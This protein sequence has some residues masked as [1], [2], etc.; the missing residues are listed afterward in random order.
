MPL[1]VNNKDYQTDNV[2]IIVIDG[3]RYTETWGSHSPTNI[4][5]QRAMAEQGVVFNNFLNED[6]TFTLSGHSAITTGHYGL[7]S[8]DGHELPSYH[9]IFQEFLKSRMFPPDSAWIITSKDKL[10]ALVDTKENQWRGSYLPSI[11]AVKRRDEETLAVAIDILTNH[12][13]KLS[14]IH[15]REPDSF[16]HSNDWD[17]YLE[18]IR[19]TDQYVADLWSII[20]NDPVYKDKTT[21]LVTNDHGRHSDGIGSGFV[22][23]GDQCIGCRHI[24]LLALGPDFRKGKVINNPYGQVD[25]APTV[26]RLLSFPWK[27]DGQTIDEL[28]Q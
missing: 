15:F 19:A 9:S 4:P 8:N 21:L 2:I 3:P 12:H 26:A 6:V 17:S 1:Q 20:Q 13:P 11:N 18:S 23:H 14:L 27:G 10:Y 7:V 22:G 24:S 5:N 16:G 25:I 28:F